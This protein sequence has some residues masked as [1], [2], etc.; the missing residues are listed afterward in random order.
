MT[1]IVNADLVG[2]GSV[3]ESLDTYRNE[4]TSAQP[5]SLP[6]LLHAQRVLRRMSSAK[7]TSESSCGA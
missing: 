3:N 5:Q 7:V 2:R 6:A 4:S 1:V